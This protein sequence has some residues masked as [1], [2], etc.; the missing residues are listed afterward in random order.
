MISNLSGQQI[1]IDGI[2]RN[3]FDWKE[4]IDNCV[5]ALRRGFNRPKTAKRRAAAFVARAAET[6]EGLVSPQ[7]L[8]FAKSLL[9]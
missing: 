5:H 9:K 7:Q 2:T 3:F 6:A 1:T 8:A 4:D